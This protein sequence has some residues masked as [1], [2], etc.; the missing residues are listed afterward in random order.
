MDEGIIKNLMTS[1]ECSSCGHSYEI[2]NIEVL[3]NYEDLWFLKISCSVCQTQYLVAAVIT[4]EKVPEI[5][6][7]LTKAELDKFMSVGKLT[8]DEVLDMYSF[9]KGFDG[10]FS[11]LFSER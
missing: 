10:D 1:I 4:E 7:D 8:A 5:V 2:D 6:T 3:G 9:L 11:R